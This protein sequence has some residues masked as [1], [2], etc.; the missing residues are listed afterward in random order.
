MSPLFLLA[1]NRLRRDYH[2]ATDRGK[3]DRRLVY[4]QER[5]QPAERLGR[6]RDQLVVRDPGAGAR[7]QVAEARGECGL[8]VGFGRTVALYTY[9]LYTGF[10]NKIGASMSKT[11]MR[12]DP[13]WRATYCLRTPSHS[14]REQRARPRQRNPSRPT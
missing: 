13:T 12:P 5:A 10:T 4:A 1:S 11:T 7:R 3:V 14:I 8:A 2:S 9:L 6:A